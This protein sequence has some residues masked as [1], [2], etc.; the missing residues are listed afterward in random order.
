[1]LFCLSIVM[2][3][4]GSMGGF[5]KATRDN[6]E[7]ILNSLKQVESSLHLE[8]GGIVGQ[9]VQYKDY[10]DKMTG[11]TDEY[12]TNNFSRLKKKLA[13]FE[14]KGGADG[15]GCGK[16][17]EDIQ[18]GLI[19]ALEQIKTKRYR[20]YNHLILIVGDYPNHG[21][22]DQCTITRNRNNIKIEDVWNQIYSDIRSLD[23]IRI[24]FMPVY[25][26]EIVTTMNRMRN[27]LGDSI[28]DIRPANEGNFTQIVTETCI[29]EYMSFAGIS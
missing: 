14:A 25:N 13:T 6:I 18:G 1:M 2:D 22:F 12:I 15:A 7:G 17:C 28:V 10:A 26:A 16:N 20:R 29:N 5:I 9:V 3:T 19:R 4:T 23:S 27:A 8:K 21:D 24:M 11:E